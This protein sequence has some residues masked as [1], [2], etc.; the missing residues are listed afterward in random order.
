MQDVLWAFA[1]EANE[2]GEL[3]RDAFYRGFSTL[4]QDV[5][6]S[7]DDYLRRREAMRQLFQLFDA[8]ESGTVDF[9]EL[10]SGLSVLCGNSAKHDKVKAA[11]QLYGT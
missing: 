1:P 6:L 5:Q 8:D 10:V 3:T 7:Q 9:A 4:Q 2:Q 11:F